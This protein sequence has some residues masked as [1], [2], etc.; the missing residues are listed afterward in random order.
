MLIEIKND[1]YFI[2]SRLKEIDENY[3]IFY[4]TRRKVFEVHNKAQIGDSYSLTVPY[5]VLD[6][7]LIEL[8]RKTRV[9]NS[10]KLFEEIDKQNEQIENKN[11]KEIVK[12]AENIFKKL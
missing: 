12:Y 9:E 5:S 8:V 10:K 11:K 7:R 6:S 1:V 4:N 3:Q 2:L